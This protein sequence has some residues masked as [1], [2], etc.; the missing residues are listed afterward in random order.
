MKSFTCK[1]FC[2]KRL[3]NIESS[4]E[5]LGSKMEFL[6]L[7]LLNL[8]KTRPTEVKGTIYFGSLLRIPLRTP[9]LDQHFQSFRRLHGK[10]PRALFLLYTL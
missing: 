8:R 7:L 6:Y 4:F 2:A 9:L 1:N 10:L 3:K 5:L